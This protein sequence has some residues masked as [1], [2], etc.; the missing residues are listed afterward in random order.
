[1][2]ELIK[3][4]LKQLIDR[5]EELT[6]EESVS[7]RHFRGQKIFEYEPFYDD[8]VQESKTWITTHLPDD[9][10]MARSVEEIEDIH[11]SENDYAYKFA[12]VKKLT[13]QVLRTALEQAEA[14]ELEGQ[15]ASA[16]EENPPIPEENI[17]IFHHKR[18]LI[19][20]DKKNENL[21]T[22]LTE[23]LALLGLE[24][25]LLDAMEIINFER[26]AR[27]D[28]IKG[29]EGAIVCIQQPIQKKI[30]RIINS[31]YD[32][33]LERVLILWNAELAPEEF[34]KLFDE[35]DENKYE[36]Q[37]AIV[38]AECIDFENNV[39]L[40]KKLNVFNSLT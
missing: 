37:C 24:S 32:E 35:E 15:S 6:F 8:W 26:K 5:G 18:L 34:E 28:K 1:M 9:I 29:Y 11:Y 2:Q 14:L 12:A 19:F 30:E 21:T 40:I 10:K 20:Y 4:Q 13:L 16:E 38:N 3:K 7:S 27:V 23:M 36:E 31:I 22:M 33:Y 39:K 17:N 25:A